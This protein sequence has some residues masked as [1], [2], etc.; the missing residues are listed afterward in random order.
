MPLV[1]VAGLVGAVAVA[2]VLDALFSQSQGHQWSAAVQATATLVLVGV[3]GV[4]VWISYRQMQLQATP[5]VA[6]RLAAQEQAARTSMPLIR[7]IKD[8]AN[9][10]IRSM[11][12]VDS[13]EEPNTKELR[14]QAVALNGPTSELFTLA[15]GL[16]TPFW[17]QAMDACAKLVGAYTEVYLFGQSCSMEKIEAIR[18]NRDWSWAGARKTY[19][20]D[21]RDPKQEHPEW[22]D[23]VQLVAL[24]KAVDQ[25]DK[26]AAEISGYLISPAEGI[27][28]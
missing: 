15:P 14:D 22:G 7:Q 20:A 18:A 6:I 27:K 25:I 16:P 1:V 13:P 26:L 17:P 24:S 23:L 28:R 9:A 10:L 11:P 3:T 21:V 12:A 5:L 4:Y 8:K 19:L 2:V